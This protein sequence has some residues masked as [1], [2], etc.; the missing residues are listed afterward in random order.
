MHFEPRSVLLVSGQLYIVMSLA[1]LAILFRRHARLNLSAWCAAGICMGA[2]ACLIGL[3]DLIPDALSMPVAN[4]LAYAAFSLKVQVLRLERGLPAR[5]IAAALVW[6]AAS[7]LYGVA[8]WTS[9]TV[10]DRQLLTCT[11]QAAG[12]TLVSLQAARLARQMNSVSV[13]LIAMIY[14]LY[15]ATLLLRSAR[16]ALGLTDGLPIS[17][18]ADYLALVMAFLLSSLFGNVGY[19][20]MALDRARQRDLAQREALEQLRELQRSQELS[21][22]ARAAVRGERHRSSQVLAHEVRQPLHNAAVSLQAAHAALSDLAEGA[23]ARRAVAQAQAVIRR[24][25]ASLDNTVAAASLLAGDGRVT[26]H[27]VELEMLVG[28]CLG[29]LPPD[30]RARVQVEHRADVRSARMEPGLV[31]LALRNLLINA[32]LYAP[33]GSP[34]VLR[35]L[36]S[37]EPL[38]LVLEVADQGPGLPEDVRASLFEPDTQVPAPSVAPGHGLGLHIVQRVALLHGGSLTWQPNEPAG[39]VF[40]LTLP[41]ATPD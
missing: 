20:G 19:M 11:L 31:R 23:E 1:V 15:G 26:R 4:S 37:D 40:R 13:R 10:A 27:E 41:Q 35:L 6:A 21:A 28:L 5:W 32:T 7:T 9:W 38:A 17:P 24:V 18:Q 25:S 36:D 14:G 8:W 16:L 39:S 22:R 29:D 34:V 33:G 3:R 30:A 12:T 2:T